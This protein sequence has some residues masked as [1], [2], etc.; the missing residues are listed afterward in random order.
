MPCIGNL[1][2]GGTQLRAILHGLGAAVGLQ[3][4]EI[5]DLAAGTFSIS[6][7]KDVRRSLQLHLGRRPAD[8]VAVDVALALILTNSEDLAQQDIGDALIQGLEIDVDEARAHAIRAR[9]IPCREVVGAFDRLVGASGRTTLVAVD[10]LDGLVALG[11]SL[12]G[13]GQ[14]LLLDQMATGLMDLAEDVQHSVVVVSCLIDSWTL[15]RER[16]VASAHERYP[17]AVYLR[18]IPSARVGAALIAAYLSVAYTR[19]GFAPPYPTWPVRSTAFADADQFSPRGLIN[20]VQDHCARC[21]E[22]GQVAELEQL[23]VEPPPPPLPPPPPPPPPD[24][25]QRFSRLVQEADVTDA[26][27]EKKVDY[28]LPPLL[29]AGLTA[30]AKENAAAGDFSVDPPPGRKPLLHARLRR[31]VDAD[32]DDEL[33]SSF[34]AVLNASPVASL[35]RLRSAV[36][37]SGIELSGERRRL[38]VLRN[39]AWSQGRRTQQVLDG[40]RAHGG[41]VVKLPE[42][43][44]RVFRALQQLLEEQPTG[45]TTWLKERRHASGTALLAPLSSE[46][47][48]SAALAEAGETPEAASPA[49]TAEPTRAGE[50]VRAATPSTTTEPPRTVAPSETV[51]TSEPAKAP[52]PVA[53]DSILIGIA[54]STSRPVRVRLEDLRRHTVIF[55][56]SGSGK[57]VLIR[58]LVEECALKG[59]SAVVL[60]PNNDLARLGLAWPEP[61]SGWNDG[62]AEKAV[63]YLRDTE[64]VVWTPRLTTGRP[65]SFAPLAG[66]GDVADDPDEFGIALD[67][68]V[69]SLVPRAGLPASGARSSQGRAVLKEALA[70]Y[71][72]RDGGDLKGFLGYLSALP[73][74]V[75]RL[76]SGEKLAADIAQTLLAETVNDPMLGGTGEAVDPSVLLQ[77]A[78]GRRARISVISLVGLPNDEQRQHFVNQ[79]QMAL[80][81][82]V[83]KHPAGD[84]PLGGLFVMDEAQTF[85]PSSGRTA[86]TDSTLALASQARKYGLG[87]VFATQAPKGLHNRIPGNATTQFYGLLNAPAQIA[88]AQ[89]MAAQKGGDA[90][91]IAR[92]RPGEFFVGSD[93]VP[94]QRVRSPMC[95]SYHPPSPMT[96]E[97][98]LELARVG[99][100]RAAPDA[101]PAGAVI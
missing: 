61:P 20:L 94:F 18:P 89:E 32:T 98:I 80:F 30:W 58:R 36:T 1:G 16:S 3:E 13:A 99:R 34:R 6:H 60:D 86:T 83:K 49:E 24:L 64:V 17:A 100:P 44:L 76:A 35:N 93:L 63:S 72:Q 8:Q 59:V 84:R 71:A 91:G 26:L 66:L 96:Q 14:Q 77:P 7:L 65:L 47:A 95:L 41:T 79:L 27:D 62:D 4:T 23:L 69:A 97:E 37:A 87:L 39:T 90:R 74:G 43:D 40:L 53:G 73:E 75:S 29:R 54:E 48:V 46:P 85:A 50:P 55:A 52:G 81:I 68:A 82:W 70:A 2:E 67:N 56:G 38:F 51:A 9:R 19:A 11:R 45:L 21:V 5:E 57:T 10:Q 42:A 88:A 92:L 15:I 101:A 25:D 31:I 78:G 28:G 12:S 22:R 33:H